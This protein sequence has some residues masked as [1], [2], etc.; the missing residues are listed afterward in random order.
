VGTPNHA[1]REARDFCR[2]LVTDPRVSSQLRGAAA[3]WDAA[4]GPRAARLALCLRQTAAARRRHRLWVDARGAHCRRD[5]AARRGRRRGVAD[6]T[7]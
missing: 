6:R 3:Q 4:A 5:R 1:T 2:R 7:L